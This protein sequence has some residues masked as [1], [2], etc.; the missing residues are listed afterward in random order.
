M[1]K[2]KQSELMWSS[3]VKNLKVR[4]MLV[5]I[6]KFYNPIFVTVTM[7]QNIMVASFDYLLN[8]FTG[9]LE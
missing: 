3:M 2:N 6:D 1:R 7:G 9:R 4:R 8:L 5:R